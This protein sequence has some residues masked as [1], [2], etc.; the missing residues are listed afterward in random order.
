MTMKT[1]E[2]IDW[3]AEQRRHMTLAYT[4][5]ERAAR[6]AF[7]KWHERKRG[8]A[9]QEAQGKMWYQ[10]RCC[11]EKGKDPAGMIG[12]LI[13]WAIMHVRYDR[14]IAGRA[15]CYDVFD[16]RAKMTRQR[17]DAQGKASAADRSDPANGWI[18]WGLETGDDPAEMI[19][20]LEQ[21]GLSIEHYLA[22]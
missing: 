4:R 3:Q 22:A 5:C 12:P 20:A 11:L 6:R 16:Y 9:V 10:W 15:P 1:I 13:H 7:K 18:D 19:A 2:G 21:V 14:R 8:D 17:L